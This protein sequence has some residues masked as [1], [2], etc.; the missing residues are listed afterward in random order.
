ML[1]SPTKILYQSGTLYPDDIHYGVILGGKNNVI[2]NQSLNYSSSIPA[3]VNPGSHNFISSG[4]FN[5]IKP[6]ANHAAIIGGRNNTIATGAA[7]SVILG[8]SNITAT[9][10]NTVYAQHI[11]TTGNFTA[12]GKIITSRITSPD[13]LIYLGDSTMIFST[14]YNRMYGDPA[15][16]GYKG[17]AIGQYA[18]AKG[19]S[20]IAIGNLVQPNATNAIVIGNGAGN[21]QNLLLSN[22]FPNSLMIGF[23]S[24]KPTLF[25]G[26]ASGAGQTGSVGIATSTPNSIYKLDVNGNV[27]IGNPTSPNS[28]YKLDVNGKINS[29]GYLL[30]GNSIGQWSN[31]NQN[32]NDIYY[33]L[34]NVGIGTSTPQ[35]KLDISG[36]SINVS[37]SSGDWTNWNWKTLLTTDMGSVWRTAQPAT[38]G[39][40]LGLGMRIDGWYWVESS[41]T[42]MSQP[43]AYPMRLITDPTYGWRLCVTGIIKAAKVRVDATGCDFVFADTYTQMT[44]QEKELFYK[45]NKHLPNI[46]AASNMENDGLDVGKNFSGLLQNAEEDR[47]DITELFKRMEKLEKESKEL[48]NEINTLKNK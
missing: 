8:G 32:L 45:I 18:I 43:P 31:S 15:N 1:K 37:K 3:P 13:S 21:T 28:Q 27:G 34:G 48:K 22:N 6:N 40:Y 38:N 16:A 23:N 36:G 11:V 10:P 41:V 35:S 5:T 44:W 4:E 24:N 42:D 39:A 47:L 33:N 19:L 9:Q 25:V 29:T 2:E 26:P 7:N 30:N 46:D 14:T 17:T 12:S 20:S